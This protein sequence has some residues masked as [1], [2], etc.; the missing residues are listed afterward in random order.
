MERKIVDSLMGLEEVF[1]G[2]KITEPTVPVANQQFDPSV[3]ETLVISTAVNVVLSQAPAKITAQESRRY[4]TLPHAI[5]RKVED[6][7]EHGFFETYPIKDYLKWSL[8]AK[9]D[10]TQEFRN[11]RDRLSS[12]ILQ[13]LSKKIEKS[14][15]LVA[16]KPDVISYISSKLEKIN[17]RGD[18][19]IRNPSNISSSQ[20]SSSVPITYGSV[21]I[22]CD[23]CGG[24]NK[25]KKEM[26]IPRE[27]VEYQAPKIGDGY[28]EEE[29]S[30]HDDDEEMSS[31]SE[32]EGPDWESM[33]FKTTAA[34]SNPIEGIHLFN[35]HKKTPEEEAMEREKKA[36]K[37][38]K[39]KRHHLFHGLIDAKPEPGFNKSDVSVDAWPTIDHHHG[40]EHEHKEEAEAPLGNKIYDSIRNIEDHPSPPVFTRPP[41]EDR[42]PQVK[43]E[44]PPTFKL[45]MI[46]R[47]QS[48]VAKNIN[49]A[50]SNPINTP[51][52]FPTLQRIE[53]KVASDLPPMRPISAAAP[54]AAPIRQFPPLFDLSIS[55]PMKIEDRGERR[56][57]RVCQRCMQKFK[58]YILRHHKNAPGRIIVFIPERAVLER[59]EKKSL[60]SNRPIEYDTLARKH[61][62]VEGKNGSLING[63]G[64]IITKAPFAASATTFQFDGK[65]NF[66]SLENWNESVGGIS[67]KVVFHLHSSLLN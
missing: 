13:L 34:P 7:L 22:G 4:T 35:R 19:F 18:L 51:I 61:I 44:A 29:Y 37:K 63:D 20:S 10:T 6:A 65:R 55:N 45:K 3:F 26:E 62:T 17:A 12:Q 28:E 11:L 48:T 56:Q 1:L 64:K 23:S 67:Q 50:L 46:G 16:N 27:M 39:K 21:F 40:K 53:N 9:N 58:E 57:E 24:K 42:L 54:T 25:K 66:E 31:S 30:D 43:N 60:E 59:L 49:N 15:G 5:T 47:E 8:N 32:G 38:N 41:Q 52:P 33:Q 14:N 36:M 2:P